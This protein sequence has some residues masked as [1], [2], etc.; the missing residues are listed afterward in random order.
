VLRFRPFAGEE[1]RP[2]Q[3][4]LLGA[5]GAERV[6]SEEVVWPNGIALASDGE[7][8]YVSDYAR[9]VVLATTLEGG[10]TRALAHVPRGSADG[11]ALDVDGGVWVALGEGGGV[12]RLRAD[13]SL[14]AEQSLPAS[15]VS[16]LAFGGTD[17]REVLITTADNAVS[18]E[19]GGTLLRARSEIAGAPVYPVRV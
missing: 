5:D 17:M 14:D 4:L 18:P 10:H 3:L 15:F 19:L 9:A 12:A 8:V 2:G 13:G 6:L 7:T 16:S 11:L 1:P